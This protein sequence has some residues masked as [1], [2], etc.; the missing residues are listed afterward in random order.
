MKNDLIDRIKLGEYD[1]C[2]LKTNEIIVKNNAYIQNE[3]KLSIF[4]SDDQNINENWTIEFNGV[5]QYH[6][7]IGITYM[8]YFKIDLEDN[9]PSLWDYLYD[10]VE[11]ELS[12]LERLKSNLMN[13]LI[14]EIA[15]CYNENTYGFIDL[16]SNPLLSQFQ[17]KNGNLFF[18]TNQKMIEITEGIF[19]KYNVNLLNK[20]IKTG[21]QK[22]WAFKPNAKVMLFRNPFISTT[23][24]VLGQTYIVADEIRISIIN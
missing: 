11:C 2:Y 23:K 22:G 1:E 14:G 6:D 15:R 9:H 5:S 13:E 4:I 21:K 8:P 16:E 3:L 19:N 20:Q 12:G 18:S 10:S 24:T 7:L 17:T